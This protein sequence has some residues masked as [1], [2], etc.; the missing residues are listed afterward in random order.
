MQSGHQA[1]QVADQR[2]TERR[3]IDYQT[4]KSVHIN[5][6]KSTHGDLRIALFKRG[7]SMQEV[8]N[9]L[10]SMVVEGHPALIKI[11]DN[12][13]VM[14]REKQIKQEKIKA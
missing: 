14:K 6:T 8:F 2:S 1:V 10:A 4:K 12:L 7:L 9:H 11:I 3:L 13:E 5:L